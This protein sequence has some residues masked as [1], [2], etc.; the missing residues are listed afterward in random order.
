[1]QQKIL[2]V[3]T[4][5]F[6]FLSVSAQEINQPDSSD[7]NID[8]HMVDTVVEQTHYYRLNGEFLKTFPP[9]FAYTVSRPF[10]WKGRSWLKA[11][12]AVGSIGGL[13]LLDKEIKSIVQTNRSKF[14]DRFFNT[15][16]PFGNRYTPY[17]LVGMFGVGEIIHDRRLS[18]VALTSAR[19]LLVSTA[20]YTGI[21]GFTRRLRP[22]SSYSQFKFGAPFKVGYTSFPSGH[23]N[24]VFSVATTVALEYK[25]VK[26]VPWVTYSLASLTGFSRVVQNRHWTSDVVTGAILGH[27]TARGVYLWEQNR[28]R[29]AQPS[30][31]PLL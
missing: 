16:E 1:M 8:S 24:T 5:L 6:S 7:Q 12:A 21:K 2:L 22:D 29:K 19:S 11:G 14:V 13:M 17:I 18:H 31:P 3:F 28:N 10:H 20:V 27:F 15:V 26:W 30:K 9:S 23:T 4:V 25:D